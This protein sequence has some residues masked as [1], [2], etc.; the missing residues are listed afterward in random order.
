MLFRLI[1]LAAVNP[2]VVPAVALPTVIVCARAA[3]PICIAPCPVVLL[4]T[5]M[6]TLPAVLVVPVA[7]PL[8]MA[9]VPELVEAVLRAAL[10]SVDPAN[11][12][13][14]SVPASVD[15]VLLACPVMVSVWLAALCTVAAVAAPNCKAEL[16][17]VFELYVP[18]AVMFPALL[19]TKTSDAVFCSCKILPVPLFLLIN[20][21][22][23]VPLSVCAVALCP[24]CTSP[25]LDMP[26]TLSLLKAYGAAV[27]VMRGVISASLP[28]LMPRYSPLTLKSTFPGNV[29][30]P[31]RVTPKTP[32]VTLTLPW[33]SSHR[34]L[35]AL[36]ILAASFVA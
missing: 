32:A 7:L 26:P 21:L 23:F 16:L 8:V 3:T 34:Q 4:P 17:N 1:P 13:T 22:E 10:E 11:P 14:V 24:S 2:I 35:F 12:C 18:V 5:S 28:T 33:V 6:V 19:I 15:Q 36:Q 27:K 25:V 31:P 9:T 29:V 20:T 30:V